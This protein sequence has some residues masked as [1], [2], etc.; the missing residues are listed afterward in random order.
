M[1]IFD[2][3]NTLNEYHKDFLTPPEATDLIIRLKEMGFYLLIASNGRKSRFKSL[4]MDLDELGVDLLTAARKPLKF[5][6]RKKNK[7]LRL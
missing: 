1:I 3:D 7:V 6:I 2:F 4:E 5:K